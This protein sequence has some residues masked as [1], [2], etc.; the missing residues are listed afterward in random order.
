MSN[1]IQKHIDALN[2]CYL[3]LYNKERSGCSKI[4]IEEI[5]RAANKLMSITGKIKSQKKS[6][7]STTVPQKKLFENN[8]VYSTKHIE[9]CYM[10]RKKLYAQHKHYKHMCPL[11]GH[12]NWAKRFRKKDLTG[13]NAVVTGGRIKIGFETALR[14]LRCGCN[15]IVSTRFANDA[16]KRYMAEDDY[17]EWRDRL[18]IVQV[19]FT[20]LNS[21]E[22][23]IR[24]IRDTFSTL[25]ILINNAAQTI[26]RAAEFYKNEMKCAIEDKHE[27]IKLVV[28]EKIVIPRLN[29]I[30]SGIRMISDIS[31]Q[32]V[33]KKASD[34][35]PKSK[36]E[37][38]V[39]V[40]VEDIDEDEI[41]EVVVEDVDG[42]GVTTLSIPGEPIDLDTI[43][44]PGKLDEFGQQIDL[45]RIN[46]WVLEMGHIDIKECVEVHLINSIV[47][48]AII[49]SLMGLMK[50][51]GNQ[52]TWIVNV[53]S[54]EG[55]FNRT[56]STCH[57]HTNMA[58]A[59]LNMMTR[60]SAG[61]LI[62][63]HIVL[64]SVDT[65]WNNNQMPCSYG[66]VT[67]VDCLDGA[68]RI[69]DPIF[70]ELKKPGVFYKDFTEHNW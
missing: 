55:C 15:V 34:T 20:K 11:C 54:M 25:D 49:S 61:T 3:Y 64:C 38:S 53:S 9:F 44:P 63:D 24:Y 26:R 29:D 43:Y 7:N 59:S 30:N 58:K 56:K 6:D 47:P 39:D 8:T 1:E 46:T 12:I 16:L 40:T 31:T 36:Q 65:G 27:N 62:K 19:N 13:K 52:F 70:R 50:R 18:Q 10:C 67:P 28:D 21:V 33:P 22:K 57:P 5:N 42:D 48:F 60:T 35:K 68:A 2:D 66:T 45:N 17:E 69:L 14:L 41:E 51:K 23:F 32:R 4:K 37:P